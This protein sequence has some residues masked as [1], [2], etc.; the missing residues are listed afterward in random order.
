MSGFC[1][2]SRHCVIGGP[3]LRRQ[4]HPRT[5]HSAARHAQAAAVQQ[6]ARRRHVQV[7]N[8]ALPSR[9]PLYGKGPIAMIPYNYQ[10]LSGH[11]RTA[12]ARRPVL[13][14]VGPCLSRWTFRRGTRRIRRRAR[15]ALFFAFRLPP[16]SCAGSDCHAAGCGNYLYRSFQTPRR[17]PAAG[18]LSRAGSCRAIDIVLGGGPD[19]IPASTP[20][21]GLPHEVGRAA[22]A[23]A[24]HLVP[25]PIARSPVLSDNAACQAAST[26]SIAPQPA[27]RDIQRP[28]VGVCAPRPDI[29]KALRDSIRLAKPFY[30]GAGCGRC[31]I[32]W[33]SLTSSRSV[34][35]PGRQVPIARP[36]ARRVLVGL[37]PK[38]E[39]SLA[40]ITEGRARPSRPGRCDDRALPARS[41][42]RARSTF[43]L[44]RS[45]SSR[46]IACRHLRPRH[47]S[48]VWPSCAPVGPGSIRMPITLLLR[49]LGLL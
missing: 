26:L 11:F 20:S 30:V 28:R 36:G 47:S 12:F 27:P 13:D 21:S 3:L 6:R 41:A 44:A 14:L 10:R 39:Q 35:C 17:W 32:P 45:A 33:T 4:R 2:R 1:A 8:S 25:R 15:A 24:M 22:S 49:V 23:R 37:G 40:A 46:T 16:I 31:I 7:P 42:D 43:S 19:L 9:R 29:S 34:A 18:L 5:S 48:A 38:T